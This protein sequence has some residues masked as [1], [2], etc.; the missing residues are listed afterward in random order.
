LGTPIITTYSIGLENTGYFYQIP[1]PDDVCQRLEDKAA[2]LVSNAMDQNARFYGSIRPYVS[3]SAPTLVEA[4]VQASESLGIKS[5]RGLTVSS[6][7]F[8]APQGR[9]TARI[10]PSVP[11]IDQLFSDFEPDL[12]G[13]KV[14]NMEMEASFLNHFMNGLGYWAGA[15]CPVIANR[16]EETFIPNYQP[17]I[18]NAIQVALLALATVRSQN[19]DVIISIE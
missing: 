7:G 4:L 10:K 6:P 16:R 12:H 3:Q 9:D 19:Q 5:Q 11:D 15:I 2:R 17:A 1:Y 18:K 14:E 13:Q 8:F